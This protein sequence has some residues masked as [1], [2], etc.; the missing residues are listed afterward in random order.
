I[1]RISIS[2]A[3]GSST[4]STSGSSSCGSG[5]RCREGLQSSEKPARIARHQS[6]IGGPELVMRTTN[7]RPTRRFHPQMERLESR[8]TPSTLVY[9]GTDVRSL[10]FDAV[11]NTLDFTTST[12]S[13]GRYNPATNSL[14]SPFNVP[15]SPSLGGVDITPDGSTLVVGDL[16]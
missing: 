7:A 6:V 5:R 13:I 16:T 9:S 14:L 8:D 15:G 11:H 1:W 12:G 4:G 2:T 10:V 3:T